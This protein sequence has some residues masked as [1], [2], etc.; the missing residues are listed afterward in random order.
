MPNIEL[1][2]NMYNQNLLGLPMGGNISLPPHDYDF[3]NINNNQLNSNSNTNAFIPT[4]NVNTPIFNN[5]NFDLSNPQPTRNPTINNMP[6][7]PTFTNN[8]DANFYK[9]E[10]I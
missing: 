6:L 4:P 10:N 1:Y 5:F 2:Q 3:N 8:P 9:T 7:N